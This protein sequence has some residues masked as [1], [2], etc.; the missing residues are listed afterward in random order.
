MRCAVL[1]Q[2]W[3]TGSPSE[4]EGKAWRPAAV[5]LALWEEVQQAVMISTSSVRAAVRRGPAPQ[6]KG[7]RTYPQVFSKAPEVWPVVF[8]CC[9][10]DRM[11]ASIRYKR[12]VTALGR[13]D[14]DG[15]GQLF[16]SPLKMKKKKWVSKQLEDCDQVH[17]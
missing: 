10:L 11:P 4:S 9:F 15:G 8:C 17:V 5:V 14:C 1:S 2:A 13:Q 7:E 16:S 12:K 6:P 3:E